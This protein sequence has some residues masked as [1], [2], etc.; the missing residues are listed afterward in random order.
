M[1]DIDGAT[2]RYGDRAALSETTL[3]IA[4]G[5]FV[6]L[7]GRNGSG[8]TTLLRLL[9]GLVPPT[10][11]TVRVD[12]VPAADSRARARRAFLQ[13]DPPLYEYLTVAEQL[14]LVARLYRRPPGPALARLEG[15]VLADRRDS[16]VRELSLGMRKQLG[17]IAATVHAP[18]LVLLDEPSNALD[19]SAA[20]ALR[21]TL[22][23]WHAEGRLIVLC[24]HDLAWAD[25]L[26]DRL[27][28]MSAGRVLHDLPLDGEPASAALR[29]LDPDGLL[30]RTDA[31]QDPGS[32]SPT[33]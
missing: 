1:I 17:L 20:A 24:T 32:E 33:T 27:A 10:S 16:L 22:A 4:P 2:V 23:Q 3:R 19:A 29:R 15:T 31:P 8:K 9:A 21:S 6:C 12:G 18:D 25:G 14:R 7:V 5:E 30:T 26:A 13:A 28:V 11:G